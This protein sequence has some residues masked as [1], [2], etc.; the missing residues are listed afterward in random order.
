MIERILDLDAQIFLYLNALGSNHGTFWL[1]ITGHS[2]WLVLFIP[3]LILLFNKNYKQLLF[4]IL[5]YAVLFLINDQLAN[6]IKLTVERPR[7]CQLIHLLKQMNF[8]APHCGAY[9]FYSAHAANSMAV[10]VFSILLLKHQQRFKLVYGILGIC[11]VLLV[12]I[13]RIMVGVHYPLDILCGW[14]AGAIIS[15]TFFKVF[16]ILETKY[17]KKA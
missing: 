7:P 17:Q 11:F 12:S 14:M 15:Y 5:A 16:K 9:G 3:L 6:L 4:I 13:S 10:V 2:F 8:I 1:F